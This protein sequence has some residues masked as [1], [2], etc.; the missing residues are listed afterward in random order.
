MCTDSRAFP[1]RIHVVKEGETLYSI[2]ASYGTTVSRLIQDNGLDQKQYLVIGQTLVILYPRMTHVVEAGESVY[3]IAGRYGITVN[4]LYRNNPQLQANPSLF[5]GQRLIIS[6]EQ[7]KIGTASIN[8][9]AYPYIEKRLLQETLPYL[10]YL[11]PFTYGITPSGDLVRLDDRALLEEADR[12]GVSTWMHLST[13]TEQ[14]NFSS[15]LAAI[16]LNDQSVQTRL[17]A[18][19]IEQIV[20]RGYQGLDIDFEFVEASDREKYPEFI[21]RL[22]KLLNPMGIPVI[23]A[24]AP[25][26]S[27]Q[28]K[29]QLYE[30]HDYRSIGEAANAVLL[31]TYE[32]GYTYGPPMA[33][34]PIQN[35]RQVLDYAVTQI[36]RKKIYLGI[37]NY[38]Y[39]WTLPFVKGQSRARSVSNQEAVE[40]AAEY[41]AEIQYD[42]YAQSPFFRYR[43]RENREHEVWFE[44]ARSIL[45]K[46]ELIPEYGFYGAG[47]WNLM[48]PF[49]QNW[50]ILNALFEIRQ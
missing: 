45:K 34:A 23:A 50:S 10:T 32:W 29:G 47:Y 48:R 21:A 4:Q 44:D 28:Q 33:V 13:L 3:G 27:S 18:N 9:Y 7:K 49:P 16:V 1:M 42:E 35:V 43:D 37:P 46:L 5:P 22:K 41:G 38:G 36:P 12:Y 8:G 14:G 30:G 40:I 26:T 31:M 19:I 20:N 2:A 25:K 6:L 17:V 15:E 39:D 24:L 11:T